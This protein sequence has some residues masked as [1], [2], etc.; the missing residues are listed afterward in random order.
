MAGNCLHFDQ[1][2]MR[3]E[4]TVSPRSPESY[5]CNQ[6]YDFGNS[7]VTP[8]RKNDGRVQTDADWIFNRGGSR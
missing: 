7:C 3:R 4:S 6:T 1:P 2:T 5:G 8:G